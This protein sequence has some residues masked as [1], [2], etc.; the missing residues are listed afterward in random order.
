MRLICFWKHNLT[1]KGG[2]SLPLFLSRT[3]VDISNLSGLLRAESFL[4]SSPESELRKGNASGFDC[5]FLVFNLIIP[6]ATDAVRLCAPDY[7]RQINSLHTSVVCA[8]LK[9]N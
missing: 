9:E 8:I 7:V 6:V 4:I 5:K 3:Q 1:Q 2:R